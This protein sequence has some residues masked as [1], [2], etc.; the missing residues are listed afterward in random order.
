MTA[1]D[2]TVVPA[3]AGSG[4]THLIETTLRSWIAEGSVRPDR[5]VAVTFTEAG[6]SELR[7]RIRQALLKE[8][9]IED[10]LSLDRSYV[11]TIHGFG[12]RLLRENAFAAGHSPSPR[13]L[14]EDEK[15]F[16]IRLALAQAHELA[17]V[18]QDLSR[19]D[20]RYDPVNGRS[21][22]DVFRAAVVG[23]IDKLRSLG[24]RGLDPSLSENARQWIATV[25]GKTIPTLP[26]ARKLHRAVE[27]LLSAFPNSMA[28]F[29]NSDAGRNAFDADQANLNRA[30]AFDRLM[31]DWKLWQSLRDMRVKKRGDNVPDTY[32]DLANTVVDLAS[33]LP[34]LAGPLGDAQDHAEALILG[35]Q[36]ILGRYSETKRTLELLDYSDMVAETEL[37]LRTHPEICD[38]F[39]RTIDCVIIDEFQDTN[40]IQFALL[41]HFVS[42][43]V[44]TMIVGDTKQAIMRFQGADSRLMEQLLKVKGVRVEPLKSNWRSVPS[45]MDFV[46]KVGAGLFGAHY[47]QLTPQLP[48]RSRGALEAIVFTARPPRGSGLSLVSMRASHIAAR[49]RDM[50]LDK[51]QKV[52]DKHLERERPIEPRDIAVLCRTNKG[53]EEYA[54]TLRGYGVKVKTDASGWFATDEIQILIHAAS[55]VINPTDHHAALFVATSTF[56]RI[57]L[58]DALKFLVQDEPINLPI[59]GRLLEIAPEFQVL[60][61]NALVSRLIAEL[62]L[63]DW[64]LTMPNAAQV[65]ANIVK[66]EAV[67]GDFMS[68]HRDTLAAAGLHG[69]GV[70]TFLAWLRHRADTPELDGQPSTGDDADAV[71]LVTWHSS[72]GREWPV[73]FVCQLDNTIE[74]RLPSQ[75][76]GFSS[77]DD[78]GKILD[79][80]DFRYAP[81]FAA[82]EQ[83]AKFEAILAPDEDGDARRV[84][85]VALTRARE[86]L[87]LEWPDYLL[88]GKAPEDLKPT[89]A[90]L[91]HVDCGIAIDAAG[92][93]YKCKALPMRLMHILNGE[94]AD[95]E[96]NASIAS[97]FPEATGRIAIH[98]APFVQPTM[99]D[100]VSPSQVE[101]V[102]GRAGSPKITVH[103][104][105]G[106]I[107]VPSGL[108]SNAAEQGT[109]LHHCVHTLLLRPELS[110]KLFSSMSICFPEETQLAISQS[111]TGLRS[112]LDRLG[113]KIVGTELPIISKQS[114]GTVVNGLIDLLGQSSQGLFVVDHKS[115][116]ITDP[117]ASASTYVPQLRAYVA[118]LTELAPNTKTIA[119]AINWLSLGS[120]A[121]LE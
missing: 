92:A 30:R 86:T 53:L 78:I 7:Q 13:L 83:R 1:L 34:E 56:G 105:A 71:E 121:I 113:I 114:N 91:L 42:R 20:Y 12:T 41:W 103:Q 63:Y 44:R 97:D 60:S 43:G 16:L 6:A 96:E 85:Y 29:A 10:A 109:A 74:P 57:P 107:V 98:R 99:L 21:G 79:G 75:L 90:R 120:I 93:S 66:F 22:E 69:Y 117:V 95:F 5:I 2:I 76:I 14:T 58:E 17:N 106:P 108:F 15:D 62:G 80:A 73:V 89:Y 25:Y 68:A 27:S 51:K 59:F 18:M 81:N 4:K 3:G 65:R 32:V 110:E 82:E 104:Y 67:A 19:F 8:G 61:V 52:Y 54:G 118:A 116:L 23:T 111:V 72:K 35:A 102:T 37:L 39:V 115:D 94:A 28:S 88:A 112:L 9:R 70:E 24:N 36:S 47:N 64:A 45:I 50:L 31:T 38:A 46:N 100:M 101:P 77:F 55:Y 26:A 11:S 84:L 119:M 33:K 49:I 40:P 87:I 48:K